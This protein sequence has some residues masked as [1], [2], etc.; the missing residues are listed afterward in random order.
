MSS[1]KPSDPALS[2]APFCILLNNHTLGSSISFVVMVLGYCFIVAIIK[3][4][5][6]RQLRK[7]NVYFIAQLIVCLPGKLEQEIKAGSWRQELME[8]SSRGAACQL[9]LLARTVC[10]PVVPRTTCSGAVPPTVSGAVSSITNHENAQHSCL[11]ANSYGDSF[12]MK[13]SH[14]PDAATL[15]QT[16]IKASQHKYQV[17]DFT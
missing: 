13:T 3:H 2:Q 15:C 11:L 4:C 12:S 8:R 10:I 6:Q 5:D 16:D 9:A 17:E 14:F 1:E 7:E